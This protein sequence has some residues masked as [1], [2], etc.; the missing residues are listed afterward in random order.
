MGQYRHN[1]LIPSTPKILSYFWSAEL[2][3]VVMGPNRCRVWFVFGVKTHLNMA[4]TTKSKGIL[5][6][7]EL[8]WWME[9]CLEHFFGNCKLRFRLL[10]FLW[11]LV[12]TSSS[13]EMVKLCK[14]KFSILSC[15]GKTCDFKHISFFCSFSRSICEINLEA[16]LFSL[17]DSNSKLV[18]ALHEANANVEQ[19]KKQLA[20]YQEETERLR[21]QVS[22]RKHLLSRTVW[23]R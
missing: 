14:F 7:T 4:Q 8:I 2:V 20:A 23:Y 18:A 12:D 21:E 22:S 15:F 9:T 10:G 6:T 1:I 5:W 19:W 3:Y 17:Q 16:E 13:T 11:V